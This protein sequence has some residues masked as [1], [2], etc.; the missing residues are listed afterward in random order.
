MAMG[1]AKKIL[2]RFTSGVLVF[3]VVCTF[4]S[5]SIAAS[6]WPE[7][8]VVRPVW[9]DLDVS[10]EYGGEVSYDGAY[11][12]MYDFPL[13][14]TGVMFT[15][16]DEVNSGDV[17]FEVEAGD[18]YLE[19]K[20][21]EL[22]ILKAE[23]MLAQTAD[24]ALISELGLLLEIEREELRR[25]KEKYPTDGK[26]YAAVPGTLYIPNAQA[27]T[28]APPGT[29]LAGIYD[30]SSKANVVFYLPEREAKKYGVGD[31]VSVYHEKEK[32][33]KWETTVREKSYD[34]ATGTYRYSA[35]VKGENLRQ[36]QRVNVKIV[37]RTETYY[38]VIPRMAV[39]SGPE[40]KNYVYIAK[41]RQGL[42]GKEYGAKLVEVEII[43]T[44][45]THAALGGW[46]ISSSD[47][48]VLS[49]SSY[50][51]PGETV[52]VKNK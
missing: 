45:D 24:N 2:Y 33:E 11:E 26:I 9:A 50:L 14:I 29:V 30:K 20:R 10:G 37:H 52:K 31:E 41:E 36:G 5:K 46:A 13:E 22:N 19:T 16:G 44:S 3:L 27:Q 1:G 49:S 32:K 28:T 18:Y 40:N 4:L 15:D 7:V 25:Y 43:G 6:V 38:T 23:N 42:F 48:V 47:D 12:F 34:A 51:T 21:K 8:E 39:I 17:L 35:P